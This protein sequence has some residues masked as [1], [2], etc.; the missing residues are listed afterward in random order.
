MSNSALTAEKIMAILKYCLAGEEIEDRV[1]VKGI[2]NQFGFSPAR[3]AEK[4]G[5]ILAALQCLPEPFKEE[6]GGG[7]STLNMC[8]DKED[9]QW[10]EQSD[11]QNLCVLAFAAGLG[12]FPKMFDDIWDA[13]PGGMP[14]FTW[15]ENLRP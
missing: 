12:R 1:I 14:Y 15:S 2:V 6:S 13:L 9:R 11:V 8:V 7:W 3:I 4:R 5:E 10:G